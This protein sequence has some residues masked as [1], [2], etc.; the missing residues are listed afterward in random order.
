MR[1]HLLLAAISVPI[2]ALITSGF[3][4]VPA[5]ADPT[6]TTSSSTTSLSTTTTSTQ[7]STTTSS[8]APSSA[9]SSATTSSTT[10]TT[11]PNSGDQLLNA[12]LAATQAQPAADWTASLS[13]PTESQVQVT[14][15]GRAECASALTVQVL[16]RKTERLAILHIGQRAYLRGNEVALSGLLGFKAAAAKEEADRWISMTP[17]AGMLFIDVTSGCSLTTIT[18]TLQQMFYAATLELLRATTVHGEDAWGIQA[19]ST[20]S[21]TPITQTLYVAANGAP[22]PVELIATV[23]SELVVLVF[24]PWGQPPGA[25]APKHAVPFVNTWVALL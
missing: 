15:A 20:V 5:V 16:G 19:T 25:K 7:S 24:G 3:L 10:T 14:E 11:T 1:R 2:S 9:T 4:I 8:S 23:Q 18:S 6:T 22:L 21:G 13:L 17:S 12:A